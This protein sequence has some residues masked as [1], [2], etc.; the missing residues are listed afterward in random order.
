M[1]VTRRFTA[2]STMAMLGAS[3]LACGPGRSWAARPAF[4]GLVPKFTSDPYFTAANQGGQKAAAELG[5]RVEYNGPVSADVAAQADIVDRMVRARVDALCVCA[6]DPNALAPALR[7]AMR[8]G[9]KVMTWDADVQADARS[10]FLDQATPEAVGKAIADIMVSDGGGPGE[11]LLI[12]ASLTA[13]NMLAWTSEIRER[14]AQVRPEMKIAAVLNGNEDIETSKDLTINYLRSHPDTKGV[15]TTDGI[16]SVGVAEAVD[17]LQL[18]G[19]L[20]VSGIGV[21]S[22]IRP[23]IKNGT[24]KAAVLWDPIHL[25]Y[26]AVYIADALLKGTLDPKS[27]VVAAGHLGSLKFI[28]ASVVLLGPPLVFTQANIDQYHF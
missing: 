10:V 24:V 14:L 1:R 11:Y 7:R 17:Q 22:S 12:T 5:L 26:A 4:V 18:N 8:R 15:F 2:T 6:N 28:D 9:V 19:R 13:T 25:G 16:A 27:G 21:P 3:A 23:Y 20:P